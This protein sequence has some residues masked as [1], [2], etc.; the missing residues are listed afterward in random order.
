MSHFSVLVF[1]HDVESLLDPYHEFECTGHND[2]Y[3]QD[4]DE[5]EFAREDY[6]R[7]KDEYVSFAAFLEDYYGRTKVEFDQAP[8]INDEHKFGYFTV[9]AND[10]VIKVIRRT[11]PNAHW[12]WYE[13]GG[14]YRDRLLLK[15]GKRADSAKKKEIDFDR[16]RSDAESSALIVYTKARAKM[17][18]TD[19]RSWEDVVDDE[20][21]GDMDARRAF[22]HGQEAVMRYYEGV[23]GINRMY[24]ESPAS[25][26]VDQETYL[27]RARNL[28]LNAY[29]M[30]NEE[31][32]WM[33]RGKMGWFGMS[34]DD[35]SEDDWAQ[36]IGSAIDALD[37]DEL[38]TIIDCHI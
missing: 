17:G 33:A 29:A 23:D 7:H 24:G 3:V 6:G 27:R 5:T 31:K 32:G 2:E 22:Y 35:Q 10:E 12:D 28:A 11:N 13:K 34:S 14:R 4:I 38:I 9:D 26:K 19:F 18:D 37:D 30:V 21:L 16:L 1:G 36:N 8:D 25:F 15:N 20:S